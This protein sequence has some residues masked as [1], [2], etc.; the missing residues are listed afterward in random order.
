MRFAALLLGEDSVYRGFIDPRR[1]RACAA[2]LWRIEQG[3]RAPQ[4]G[5][6]SRWLSFVRGIGTQADS[7]RVLLKS[8]NHTFRLPWLQ[9]CFPQAQFIWIGRRSRELLAS[10]TKM[11][12][13]MMERYA[14]WR[15]PDGELEGFLDD[16][17]RACANVLSE[18]LEKISPERLLW[19][20]FEALRTSPREVLMRALDFLS[21]DRDAACERQ[22]DKALQAIPIHPGSRALAQAGT[23]SERL[24]RLMRAAQQRFGAGGVAR[25]SA[26]R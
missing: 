26:N 20:S 12:R 5:N 17:L 1:L 14:L 16:T 10:N 13:A 18:S 7:G 4:Q 6:L 11:W 9:Q 2:R 19:L 21:V 8:P 25:R 23:D 24:D 22:L 15:C 3:S